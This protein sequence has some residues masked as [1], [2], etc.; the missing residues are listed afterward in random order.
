MTTK[1]A[2]AFKI[3]TAE[4]WA[5]FEADGHFDGAPVDLADGGQVE[6]ERARHLHDVQ[7]LAEV[8]QV[9]KGPAQRV[10]DGHGRGPKALGLVGILG[11]ERVGLFLQIV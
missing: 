9:E 10:I 1:P 2:T 8:V 7:L 11:L 5:R 6:G 4:Q 3:L